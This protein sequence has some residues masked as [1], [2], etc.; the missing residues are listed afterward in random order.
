VRDSHGRRDN[1]DPQEPH[2]PQAG[3]VL[4][5][6]GQLYTIEARGKDLPE[7][8]RAALRQAESAPVVAQ[9]RSWVS[10]RSFHVS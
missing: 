8:D 9:V 4:A 10:V 7:R 1:D 6:I 5:L 3:E 2:Y